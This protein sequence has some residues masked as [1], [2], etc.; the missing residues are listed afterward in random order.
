[1]RGLTG[2]QMKAYPIDLT[3]SFNKELKKVF[4]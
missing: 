2:I 4:N 1:M 3:D